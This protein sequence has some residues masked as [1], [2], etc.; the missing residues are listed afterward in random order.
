M[1]TTSSSIS[2]NPPSPRTTPSREPRSR[3]ASR[4][5]ASR[6]SGERPGECARGWAGPPATRVVS[7]RTPPSICLNLALMRAVGLREARPT[8]SRTRPAASKRNLVDR[9]YRQHHRDDDEGHKDSHA[10]DDDRLEESQHALEIGP[11]V[12]L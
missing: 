4:D 3:R 6:A 5:F 7:E 9:K 1:M 2:V 8:P 12:G 11:H 10:K